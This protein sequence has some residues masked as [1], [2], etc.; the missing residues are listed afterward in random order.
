MLFKK[1]FEKHIDYR[2]V[3]VF[4]QKCWKLYLY[5][6]FYIVFF[7]VLNAKVSKNMGQLT[8]TVT[9]VIR[10]TNITTLN[11]AELCQNIEIKNSGTCELI[12]IY[13]NW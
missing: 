2:E 8:A 4:T 9:S 1:N 10:K 3:G 12:S 13:W 5:F 7:H 6:Y 11:T